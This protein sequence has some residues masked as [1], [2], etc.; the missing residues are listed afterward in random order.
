MIAY[1]VGMEEPVADAGTDELGNYELEVP[2][3]EYHVRAGAE[4]YIPEWYD[5]A[6]HREEATVL[7]VNPESNPD[8]IVFVLDPLRNTIG[9]NY[10]NPFNA[11]TI[12]SF[13]LADPAEVELTIFNIFGQKV[14]I[15]ADGFY[16]AGSHEIIWDGRNT[17]GNPVSSGVY[18]YRLK[19][20]ENSET[21]RMTLLK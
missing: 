19:I 11:H 15:L 18:Y 10:P 12:V 9:Q 6:Q 1:R 2:H 14:A 8:G 20:G 7:V 13:N 4:G 21:R 17:N 3:G 5:N 16:Q